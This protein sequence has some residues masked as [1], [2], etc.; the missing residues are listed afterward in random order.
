MAG[1][2]IV[3]TI[4]YVPGRDIARVAGIVTAE[5]VL[6]TGFLTEFT[7]DI[8]DLF[9]TRATEFEMKWRD[10]KAAAL[11]E[12]KINAVDIGCNAVSEEP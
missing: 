3:V 7:T 1:S 4:A 11:H 8:A 9:G 6:G 5:V 10:A 12:L 2:V